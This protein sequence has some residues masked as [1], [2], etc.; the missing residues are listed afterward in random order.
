MSL[1]QSTSPV[2]D[3]GTSFIEKGTLYTVPSSF[4]AHTKTVFIPVAKGVVPSCRNP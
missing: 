1:E 2:N 3:P 4:T